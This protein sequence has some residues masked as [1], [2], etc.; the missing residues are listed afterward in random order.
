MSDVTPKLDAETAE[1]EWER[2][3]DE[4]DLF[5]DPE[6]MDPEEFTAFRKQKNLIIRALV[7]GHLVIDEEGRPTYTPQNPKSRTHDPITFNERTGATV[8]SGDN[9][10]PQQ[11]AARGYAAMAD[12]TGQPAKV[13]AGLVGRD[14][15]TCEAL[16]IFLMD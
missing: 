8:M 4:N 3:I 2:F 10:K 15:K 5:L 13:F 14:I 11:V 7:D 16:F 6:L 1:A 12:M 9:K